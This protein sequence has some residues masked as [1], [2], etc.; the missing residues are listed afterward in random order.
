MPLWKQIDG[1]NSEKSFLQSVGES[2]G[3]DLIT[4]PAESRNWVMEVLEK[5]MK[6]NDKV[7]VG[8]YCYLDGEKHVKVSIAM[9]VISAAVASKC[10]PLPSVVAPV[11]PLQPC[12]HRYTDRA[13]IAYL[14]T[15]TDAHVISKEAHEA[16]RSHAVAAPWC[17]APLPLPHL[18]P[19]A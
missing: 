4:Q 1:A 8:N 6:P 7:T 5:N 18:H 12:S 11:F 17:P 19:R 10:V 3:V 13:T 16:Q 15:P 9:D 2:A 14:C